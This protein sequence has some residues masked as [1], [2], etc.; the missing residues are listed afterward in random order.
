ML[1]LG[2]GCRYLYLKSIYF[3]SGS[4]PK[5]GQKPIS[6]EDLKGSGTP[7]GLGFRGLGFRV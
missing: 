3:L 4:T 7:G 6:Q 1:V 5:E 2:S